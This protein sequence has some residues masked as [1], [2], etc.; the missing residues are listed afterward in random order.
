MHM[1]ANNVASNE[2]GRSV[3]SAVLEETLPE[4]SDALLPVSELTQA[5]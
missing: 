3:T 5:S 4:I 2:A 1:A